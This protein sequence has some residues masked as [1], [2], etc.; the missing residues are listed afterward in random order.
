ML[1]RSQIEGYEE[2]VC[3]ACYIGD[4]QVITYDKWQIKQLALDTKGKP[5]VKCKISSISVLGDMTVKFNQAMSVPAKSRLL[6]EA[7]TKFLT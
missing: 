6:Q 4:D 3:L 2:N 1:R 5:P 7:P